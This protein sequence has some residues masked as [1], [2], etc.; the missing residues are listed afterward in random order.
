MEAG[1]VVTCGVGNLAFWVL[2]GNIVDRITG[3][4]GIL[5]SSDCV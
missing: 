5:P 3:V 4:R 1:Y 2:N